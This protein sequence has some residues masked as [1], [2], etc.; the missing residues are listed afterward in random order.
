MEPRHNKPPDPEAMEVITQPGLTLERLAEERGLLKPKPSAEIRR[1]A[2]CRSRRLCAS[3]NELRAILERHE[4]TIQKRWAKKTKA[5]RQAILL[6]LWP[7]MATEYRPDLEAFIHVRNLT[8]VRKMN[9]EWFVWPYIN[10]EDLSKSNMLPLLANA[11]GRHDPC[12]FAA[13]DG[14]AM[15]M[16]ILFGIIEY[17]R[18]TDMVMILNG[19]VGP[20]EYGKLLRAHDHPEAIAW[21]RS[22]TQFPP[23]QGLLILEAQE[24]LLGFLV[25]WC[26]H[27]LHDIPT[28]ALTSEAFP[29][30]PHPPQKAEAET[31]GFNSM[32]V[33]AAEA[34]YR[35]PKHVDF[36]RIEALLAAKVSALEDYMWS[37]REDPGYFAHTQREIIEHREEQVKDMCGKPHMVLEKSRIHIF[38]DSVMNQLV[39]GAYIPLEIYTELQL[40]A[41]NLR[42][43]HEKYS[44]IISPLKPL[45]KDY[46]QGI[47][48]FRLHLRQAAQEP[49]NDLRNCITAS[50]PI[51]SFW[52]RDP[53]V[54]APLKKSHV[55]PKPGMKSDN[56]GIKLVKRLAPLWNMGRN[57]NTTCLQKFID[58]VDRLLESEQKA[59]ELVSSYVASIIG[60]LSIISQCITQLDL[61]QPWASGF[62]IAMAE[63]EDDIRE[64]FRKTSQQIISINSA[65]QGKKWSR[66]VRLGDVS[67]GR[68]EYPIDKRRTRENVDKLRESEARLDAFWVSVDELVRANAGNLEGLAVRR[69]LSQPRI[70]QRTPEWIEPVRDSKRIKTAKTTDQDVEHLYK[71]LSALYFGVSNPEGPDTPSAKTKTKTRGTAEVSLTATAADDPPEDP[72]ALD[73]QPTIAV[74][75]RALKVFRTLFFNP[76]PTATP[77]E[78]AW[79]DFLH[80]LTSAGFA[81]E[82]LYGSV[83]QFR[84]VTLSVDRSIQ[85]HEPHPSGKIPFR[86]ARR[87]GRR[88]NRAYGWCGGMFV[89]K[90]K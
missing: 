90:E 37:L 9:R 28:P 72:S 16:G 60:E 19:A 73:S 45:P 83:W 21:L 48:R 89:L 71:P 82:K 22:R 30:K 58:D 63:Y 68:F 3:H 13:A 81:A 67:T 25:S 29:I 66:A 2:R 12:D 46:M 34:P 86:D 38:R 7:N 53:S 64:E 33:M 57:I 10:Q 59:K 69:L 65:F 6:K 80:A 44:P 85:F 8:E 35:V 26:K 1:E 41:R 20:D 55:I 11:R 74:N 50:P 62:D 27:V 49:I 14:A 15:E 17:S 87:H 5:Q 18:L 84:P 75:A 24:M 32:A 36:R 79:N 56:L 47:L 43:L 31:S 78:I 23:E 52:V 76:S 54:D 51:R 4:A 39:A 61:Y 77:G 88:L 40:Q 42:L 70:L